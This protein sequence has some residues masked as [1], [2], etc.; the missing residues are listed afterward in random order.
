[1]KSHRLLL[2]LALLLLPLTGHA[3]SSGSGTCNASLMAA[4]PMGA[5]TLGTGGYAISMPNGPWTPGQ[6][7]VV[8]L[9]GPGLFK[10]LL[11]YATNSSGTRVGSFAINNGYRSMPECSG[12]MPTET[13][14]HG[15]SISKSVPVDFT[16]TAPATDVGP[17]TV[18]AIVL[19]GFNSYFVFVSAPIS[20]GDRVFG[21]GFEP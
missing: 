20:S 19:L 5:G 4:A 17:I 16:W 13:F 8:R 15:S 14:T 3:F 21:N 1:M 9:S 6:S 18:N 11:M 12:S 7:S 10:G 2:C